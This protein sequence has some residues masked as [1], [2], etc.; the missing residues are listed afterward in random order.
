MEPIAAA[1]KA[2]PTTEPGDLELEE[3]RKEKHRERK[4]GAGETNKNKDVTP[5]PSKS[6][7]EL[8]GAPPAK[9][10][11]ADDTKGGEPEAVGPPRL[12]WWRL[13]WIFLLHGLQAWG[14]PAVQIQNLK[15]A[16]VIDQKWVTVG[17][18]NR[19]FAV[20][21]VSNDLFNVVLFLASY[22]LHAG[23]SR[24]GGD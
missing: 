2:V 19:V 12:S 9:G 17:K 16:L 10:T 13:Y 23:T 7:P 6:D 22:V 11:T 8:G 15:Q 3:K 4:P 5:K 24:T 18:F 14:G 21:Q 20:Y 1:P